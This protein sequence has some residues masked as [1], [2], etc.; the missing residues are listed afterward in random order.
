MKMTLYTANCRGDKTNTSYPNRVE[1]NCPADLERAALLDHVCAE[2]RTEDVKRKRPDGTEY[3]QTVPFHRA[4]TAFVKSDCMPF[5][6]DNGHSN[7]PAEW[8][9]L[10]SIKA[11]FPGVMFYAVPSRNHMKEKEQGKDKPPL[12]ARPRYHI[13]FPI[14]EITDADEYT[15]LKQRVIDLFPWFDLNAKDAARFLFGVKNPAAVFVEGADV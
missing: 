8:K 6:L 1:V 13:Y 2:Y 5:D 12:S 15:R 10:D 11:A 7:D 9:T 4:I 3:T 14:D